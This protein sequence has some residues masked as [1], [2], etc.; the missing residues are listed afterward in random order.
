MSR[1]LIRRIEEN[2]AITLHKRT[3]I[4]ALEGNGRLERVQ[5][6]NNQTGALETHNIRHVFMMTGASPNTRWLEGCV[7]Q[8]KQGFIKTGPN[9]MKRSEEHTSELQSHSDLVCRLLL[10]IGRAHV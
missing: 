1:Y 5:W 10:E 8:D 9:L 4:A 7:V 2:P 6:R 3:E